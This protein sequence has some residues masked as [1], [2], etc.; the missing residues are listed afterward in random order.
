MAVKI[1]PAASGEASATN[2]SLLA[3]FSERLCVPSC[4]ASL[5]E[6]VVTVSYTNGTPTLVDSTVFV[7]IK[8]TITIITPKCGCGYRSRGCNCMNTQI[9]V[10]TFD[11]AFNGQTTLPTTVDI[12]SNGLKITP[13]TVGCKCYQYRIEDSINVAI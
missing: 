5:I 2:L 10:E 3:E 4:Q 8:A 12:I 7:P 13:M 1:L 11:A 6:P 9:F